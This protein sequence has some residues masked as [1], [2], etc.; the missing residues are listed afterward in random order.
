VEGLVIRMILLLHVCRGY[1][2]SK[3]HYVIYCKVLRKVIKGAK[4]QHYSR[5]IAKSNNKN[6]MEDYKEKT[7]KMYSVEQ[8][9]TL[10]VND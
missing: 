5:L 2:K 1:S 3:V 10:V 9:P 8:G 6:N 7:G 4:K